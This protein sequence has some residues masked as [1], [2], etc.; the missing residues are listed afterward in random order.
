MV[1]NLEK[2][3]LG[4]KYVHMNGSLPNL[5]RLIIG[6]LYEEWLSSGMEWMRSSLVVNAGRSANQR[7]RGKFVMIDYKSSKA[8]YGP[9]VARQLKEEKQDLESKKNPGDE[10][11]YWMRNPDVPH[12]EDWSSL[13]R[14]PCPVCVQYLKNNMHVCK[15]FRTLCAIFL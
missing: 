4:P 8:K 2:E 11:I 14:F 10:T 1:F 6:E 7:R 3:H 5:D 12:L 13:F 9:A 15:W